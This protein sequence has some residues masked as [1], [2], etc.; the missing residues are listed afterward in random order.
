M[1]VIE[2]IKGQFAG[3]GDSFLRYPVTALLS[4]ALMVILIIQNERNINGIYE[5]EMLRRLAMTAAIGML[6]SISLKH[7][8]ERFWPDKPALILVAAPSALLMG[9]YY[10]FFTEE[11]N[12]ISGIR[13]IGFLL[14]LIIAL[15]Y[16]LKLKENRNYEP[17]VIR[18]F[19]G[20]FI[21]VLYS[22]VLYFG[23]SAIIFTINAL[24]DA[25]IDGKWFFYF[26]LMVTFIFG[27]LMFLSK[28]PEKE[29]SFESYPYSKALKILLL[30]IVI[31]LIT[32]YTGILYVYFIKILVTQEWP[33]GLVSNL[34]LW[35]SVV[36][37]AVI[38][39]ITPIL[40]ENRLAEIFRTWFPRILLP[41]L[42]M[43]FVSIGK[44]IAQYGVTENR[45]FVVLLGIW[46]LLIMV[47]FIV[48]K[49]LTNIFIPV[50][51]SIFALVSILGPLSA[52]SVSSFSQNQRFTALLEKNDMLQSGSIQPGTNVSEEDRK[53]ISS[54]VSYFDSRDPS[55]IKYLGDDYEYN[56]FE[57]VFGFERQDYY[58]YPE[59]EYIYLSSDMDRTGIDIKGYDYLFTVNYNTRTAETDGI[60]LELDN[61]TDLIVRLNGEPI[62]TEDLS[63]DIERIVRENEDQ[64][65]KAQIAYED[66]IILK[67]NDRV[68]VKLIL[69][70]L[71]AR[72]TDSDTLDFDYINFN[73]LLQMKN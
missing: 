68:S 70:E 54:I 2:R 4:I 25:D 56:D 48:K 35:Y 11:M 72:K 51:L 31:P 67:E 15:F 21:T 60:T 3:L 38:F 59:M 34:V 20:F 73:I 30:Y 7:L 61:V 17:Y 6:A 14:T 37:A 29:E 57:S 13:F 32:I 46:V 41:I 42:A 1:K 5:T 40:E 50:T 28:L 12:Q 26:F 66:S 8:Q 39:F 18:I 55:K 24:F 53:N 58:R 47:Y 16:T 63:E 45:Y 33:R 65:Q 62:M 9:L 23:I 49:K 22:G 36:S 44:R 71:S 19:N 52:F 43:M 64:M 27:A 69:R 10:F